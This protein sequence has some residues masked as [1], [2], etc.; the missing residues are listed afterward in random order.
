M[1]VTPIIPITT[2]SQLA[3]PVYS[4][5]VYSMSNP[6]PMV[7]SCPWFSLSLGKQ[8]LFL[9]M[10]LIDAIVLGLTG[11]QMLISIGSLSSND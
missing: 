2:S 4:T 8:S 5:F 11:Q 7:R 10:P 6:N 9:S 3:L 1:L